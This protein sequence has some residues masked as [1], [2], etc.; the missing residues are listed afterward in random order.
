[1]TFTVSQ[2]GERIWEQAR[3]LP[4]FH[5]SDLCRFGITEKTARDYINRWERLGRIRLVRRDEKNRRYFSPSDRPLP[6]PE[7]VSGDATP[8]GNMWRSMR[9]LAQFSPVDVAAHANAGGVDVTID[10][11]RAYCRHLLASGHLRVRQ[12][13]IPGVREP[14]YQLIDDTGP[15]APHPMRVTGLFDPN[16]R[17]FVPANPEILT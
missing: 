3:I 7:P 8:E 16:T 5:A 10:K 12:T 14:L 6:A 4:E 11:A 2:K 13:A 17:R 9:R 1:M 15:R